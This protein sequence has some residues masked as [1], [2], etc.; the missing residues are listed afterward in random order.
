MKKLLTL[1]LIFAL[2]ALTQCNSQ[3]KKSA[4]H[5]AA[6]ELNNKAMGFMR[7]QNCDSAL[8]Y[9]DRAI[10]VDSNSYVL[11]SNKCA[12]YCSLKDYQKA[13]IESQKV[14]NIK[15]DL[16]EGWTFSGMLYDKLGDT[17]NALKSY[18]KSIE[19]FDE[20]I[21][22]PDKQKSLEGNKLNR[23][24]SLILMG[25]EEMGRSELKKLKIAYPQDNTLDGFLNLTKKDYFDQIFKD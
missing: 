21:S 17:I 13:L 11:H 2:L 4:Y 7:V 19:I 15:T 6:I 22:N 8:I 18:R 25:Q 9:L 14:I 24:F 1:H 12:V 20:R 5:V 16:A 10:T 3:E 23:A